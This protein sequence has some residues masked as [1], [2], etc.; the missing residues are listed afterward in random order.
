MRNLDDRSRAD[1]SRPTPI[2]ARH[3]LV[4]MA[5]Q[6][7]HVAWF[8]MALDAGYDAFALAAS[9]AASAVL[10][11]WF[12]AA[13][14]R[15]NGYRPTPI[16]FYLGASVFRL[17]TGV[18]FVVAAMASDEW[19][20][21]QVG[22]QDVASYLMHGHWLALIGDW[23]VVAGYF[24]VVSR[25]RPRPPMPAAT[26]PNLW[27]RVWTAGLV[28]SSV[29]GALRLSAPYVALGG[30]DMLA[31]FVADY[32]L[33]AGVLLMLAAAR[34]DRRRLRLSWAAVAFA[35]LGLDVLDGLFSYMKA[36]VLIAL[37]PLVVLAVDRPT[38]ARRTG[39]TA[40]GG[41]VATVVLVAGFFMFLVAVYSSPRRDALWRAGVADDPAIRY[42]VP[43]VPYLLDAA[44]RAVPGTE[45][46]AETHR[47]PDG[48]WSL[49]GRMS[50]TAYP[51]WAYRQVEAVGT[52][53][54]SFFEELL[55]AVTPRI[56]WPGKP[57]ISF[58]RDFA[59][60]LGQAHSADSA[61]TS[62]ALTLQAAYYWWG[63]YPAL[64]LGCALTGAGFALVWL[65][66]RDQWLLNPA[67]AL[68]GLVM[69]HEGFRWF[70]SAVL[71]SFPLFLYVVIVFVPLQYAARRVL[72][73]RPASRARPAAEW[74]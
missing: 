69:C 68:V 51:S 48:A 10:Y 35:F 34:Y 43:V 26:A 67:S 74:A 60:T 73:Y 64:V 21:V 19:G 8:G 11:C 37:L 28:T 6:L 62:T 50:V 40:F 30:A 20:F 44:R 3:R 16:L 53:Q 55:V 24:L 32:G 15:W 46:F 23:C 14:Y 27:P 71:G 36:D 33:A 59:V 65:L 66:F 29:G 1:G 52:R 18:L 38:R 17:G 25:F 57:E 13:E 58:G 72:G 12:L 42:N 7:V 70:E 56:L 5:L 2:A 47:F 39:R 9:G 31:R 61:T 41:A 4:I 22:V 45:A 49:I 63:G 54:G